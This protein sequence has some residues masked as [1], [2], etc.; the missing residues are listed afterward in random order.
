MSHGEQ[1]TDVLE[2][3]EIGSYFAASGGEPYV[4]EV[5]EIRCRSLK[6]WDSL[7]KPYMED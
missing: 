2:N 7:V 5:N 6:E 3:L 1:L 4:C